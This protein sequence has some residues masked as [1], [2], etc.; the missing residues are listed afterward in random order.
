MARFLTSCL[1]EDEE[2]GYKGHE[3]WCRTVIKPG[4]TSLL[5]GPPPLAEHCPWMGRENRGKKDPLAN[6]YPG[7]MSASSPTNQPRRV[8]RWCFT[9]GRFPVPSAAVAGYKAIGKPGYDLAGDGLNC[10]SP[11][12][13]RHGQS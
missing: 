11:E 13:D 4:T 7:E 9:L 12:V 10:E 6:Y 2:E 5:L 1:E 8:R 3:F